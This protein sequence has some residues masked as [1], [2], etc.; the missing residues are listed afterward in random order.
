MRAEFPPHLPFK[1]RY[2]MNKS[3]SYG[4]TPPL[5]PLPASQRGEKDGGSP[6]L[7]LGWG[8]GAGG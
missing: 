4:F 6:F 2:S 8:Q 5:N 3:D 1:G 7:Q